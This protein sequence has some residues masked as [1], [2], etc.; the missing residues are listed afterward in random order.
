[1]H[2]V[3]FGCR[4]TTRMGDEHIWWSTILHRVCICCWHFVFCV[5]CSTHFSNSTIYTDP[6]VNRVATS[7]NSFMALIVGQPMWTGTDSLRKLIIYFHPYHCCYLLSMCVYYWTVTC[8]LNIN[9]RFQMFVDCLL[10][11]SPSC[12]SWLFYIFT[13]LCVNIVIVDSEFLKIT[14]FVQIA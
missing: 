5:F 3:W 7:R 10:H 2:C 1:M 4:F 14:L 11:F 12:D 8:L 13:F 6:S 9:A